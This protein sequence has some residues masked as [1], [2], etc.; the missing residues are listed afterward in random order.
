[1]N[2]YLPS[3]DEDHWPEIPSRATVS[4]PAPLP[5]AAFHGL[6]GDV[7]SAID[8]HTESDPAAVLLML[9]AASGNMIGSKAHFL[10]EARQH[11]ARIFAILVGE[12]AKGRKGSAWSSLRHVLSL[13]D[14]LWLGRCTTSGLSSGEGLIWNVRDPIMRRK[15]N[16]KGEMEDYEED[17]GVA[18]KR[19]FTVEEE[20]GAVLKVASRDSNTLSDIVR[21]AW[22]HGDLRTLTKNSPAVAT[23]AH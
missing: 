12:T 23:G 21:R 22:D 15:R 13:V 14:E 9:L 3:S 11:P 20:F 18:D 2:E 6:A 7:T 1:M 17:A 16:K 19:L 8:P 5:A 4:F 10:A